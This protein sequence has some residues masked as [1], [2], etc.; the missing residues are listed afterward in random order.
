MLH[1]YSKIKI[2]LY[3]IKTCVKWNQNGLAERSLN[4]VVIEESPLN[5]VISSG[6]PQG[7]LLG[8]MLFSIFCQPSG[9]EY[10]IAADKIC[11]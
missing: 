3:N 2:V 8:P 10:K 7:L 9:S 11:G 6:V 1:Q 5:G 4:I